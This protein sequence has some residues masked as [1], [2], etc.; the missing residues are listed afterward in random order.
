MET[1]KSFQVRK[2]VLK[3]LKIRFRLTVNTCKGK[4]QIRKFRHWNDSL[5]KRIQAKPMYFPPKSL[6]LPP[7]PPNY[8]TLVYTQHKTMLTNREF[9]SQGTYNW[10]YFVN[11]PLPPKISKRYIN[12]ALERVSLKQ[13]WTVWYLHQRQRHVKISDDFIV[14]RR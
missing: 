3:L 2:T 4:F 13:K 11:S 5:C 6:T 10:G 7:L 8:H 14:G 1:T 12:R 9:P